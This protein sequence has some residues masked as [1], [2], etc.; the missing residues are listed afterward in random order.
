MVFPLVAV[1]WDTNFDILG[2]QTYHLT[3]LVLPFYH[4]EDHFVSLGTFEGIMEGRMGAQNQMTELQ[5]ESV[6]FLNR[7]VWGDWAGAV[8]GR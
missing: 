8:I 7:G 5:L 1:T 2:V 3:G 6:S 4:P